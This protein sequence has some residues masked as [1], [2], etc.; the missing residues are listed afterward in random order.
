[1]GLILSIQ[2]GMAVG[3]TTA[4]QWLAEHEPLVNC[5]FE[6]VQAP[7][8]EVKRRGL[9]KTNYS[10]YLEIQR[11]FIAHEV[12]RWKSI[13]QSSCAVVDLGAGEIEFYT[14]HYPRSIGKDWPIASALATELALLQQCKAQHTLFLHASPDVLRARK[15]ADLSRDRG[16]FEHSTNMLLPMKLRWFHTQP[17][18]DFLCTD[19]LSKE[20]LCE[21]VHD[22]VRQIM[23]EF[24]EPMPK[25]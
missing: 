18:T 17:N 19:A 12:E 20:Q 4:V 6:D 2:G 1:M 16:F 13:R 15:Q 5:F 9:D 10:D 22:W 3:K 21:Q 25:K 23:T 14:L 7:L 8:Q 24:G 11:I